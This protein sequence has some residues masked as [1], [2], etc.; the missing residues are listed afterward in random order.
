[1]NLYRKAKAYFSFLRATNKIK[2]FEIISVDDIN[3]TIVA[4]V[5]FNDIHQFIEI[6]FTV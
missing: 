4:K 1:M 6:N 2:N 3:G 5:Q